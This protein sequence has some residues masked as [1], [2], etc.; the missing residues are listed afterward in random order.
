MERNHFLFVIIIGLLLTSCSPVRNL[1]WED[2]PEYFN[3][4]LNSWGEGL[5]KTFD[6]DDNLIEEFTI[7]GK[8]II[9]I[10]YYKNE[11]IS[12]EGHLPIYEKDMG[13]ISFRNYYKRGKL[14]QSCQINLDS[15]NRHFDLETMNNGTLKIDSLIKV[16]IEKERQEEEKR[17]EEEMN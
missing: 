16:G 5:Q 4:S 6:D 8:L 12:I 13:L 2:G 10:Y 1:Y 15:V 3:N 11:I 14:V 7:D 9:R 17:L